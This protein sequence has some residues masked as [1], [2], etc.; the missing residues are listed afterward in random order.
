MTVAL[1]R[2]RQ[3]HVIIPDDVLPSAVEAQVA[4]DHINHR[5]TAT[6]ID[7]ENLQSDRSARV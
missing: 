7:M 4:I 3:P 6:E 2:E 5:N 1:E